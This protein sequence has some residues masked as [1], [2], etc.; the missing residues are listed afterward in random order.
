MQ[1]TR[2]RKTANL[3]KS[4]SHQ[5]NM[6]TLAA[7]AAG[8]G[9]LA[10][11]QPAEAKI[12]YTK[13]HKEIGRYGAPKYTLDL[14][15]DGIADFTINWEHQTSIIWQF[16]WASGSGT[17]NQVLG[18]GGG[19]TFRATYAAAL[20]AGT[21]IGTK[22]KFYKHGIMV[23]MV[24]GT[25]SSYQVSGTSWGGGA[26]RYLGLKFWIN[27]KV[28]YGWAR[29][30]VKCQRTG[31]TALLTGYAY[32]TIANKPIIAGKTKGAGV[33]TVEPA[34]LGHLAHGAAAIPAWRPQ[35]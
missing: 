35:H 11:A 10:L 1:S 12:V 31:S 34:S 3:S 33:V 17:R 15:H 20:K 13:A 9:V 28:H 23:H 5:L 22:D 4:L 30:S 24:G 21:S 29:L 32:E 2:P 27:G 26:N 25:K 6:Y 14:N 19:G 18:H 7:T 16:L 8:V